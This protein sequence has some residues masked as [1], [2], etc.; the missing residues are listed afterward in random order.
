MK[1]IISLLIP[2]ATGGVAGFFT[3]SGVKGWY[4]A[5]KKPSFNPPNWLFAPVW[6][7]LY[8]MMGVALYLVW[9][10]QLQ[11]RATDKR[12]ALIY[13][14]IQM[15]LNFFWSFIFFYAH[16]PGWAFVEIVALW[17]MILITIFA[18]GKISSTAAWLLVPYITWVT[19]ATV[20]N[21]YIWKLN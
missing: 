14:G 12:K 3:N 20:L 18:F 10:N 6:T 16:Q 8:V 11:E 9:K 2:L 13:F 21:F 4:V 19:F 17:L 1:F 15:V 5:A 7:V